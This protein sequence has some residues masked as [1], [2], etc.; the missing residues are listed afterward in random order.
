MRCVH[1]DNNHV[2]RK[3]R[4]KTLPASVP[5]SGALCLCWKDVITNEE[6]QCVQSYLHRIRVPFHM[7]Q[8]LVMDVCLCFFAP[9]DGR[10]SRVESFSHPHTNTHTQRDTLGDL[11]DFLHC[12]HDGVR[13]AQPA[14][15]GTTF[16]FHTDTMRCGAMRPRRMLRTAASAGWRFSISLPIVGCKHGCAGSKRA[17]Y[18]PRY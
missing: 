2:C 4:P 7:A 14:A 16:P 15:N 1:G 3:Y 6:Q 12:Y 5:V 18:R 13:R 8:Q 10:F 11:V 17:E 9:F